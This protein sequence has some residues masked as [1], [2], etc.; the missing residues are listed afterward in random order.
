MNILL[1]NKNMVVSKLVNL[2]AD[3]IGARLEESTHLLD[4]NPKGY[5]A[6]LI[7]ESSY[8]TRF[9]EALGGEGMPYRV[10]L[11]NNTNPTPPLFDNALKKPF[12]PRDLNALFKQMDTIKEPLGDTLNPNDLI[13]QILTL[14]PQKIKEILAGAKVSIT[15]EF[16]KEI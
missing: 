15:I 10:L 6:I 14:E 13:Q 9:Q 11:K 4:R 5:D 12:L 16:P 1:L 7:D 3:E 8:E 2:W